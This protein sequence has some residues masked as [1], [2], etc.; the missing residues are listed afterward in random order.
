M[1]VVIGIK[2]FLEYICSHLPCTT[3]VK[4]ISVLNLGVKVPC[5][6]GTSPFFHRNYPRYHFHTW[7]VM[8]AYS[9]FSPSFVSVKIKQP[10]FEFPYKPSFKSAQLHQRSTAED[11]KCLLSA[12]LPT[13]WAE[14]MGQL[15]QQCV[16][17]GLKED[18]KLRSHQSLQLLLLLQREL[19]WQQEAETQ[20]YC[21]WTDGFQKSGT[22]LQWKSWWITE[23]KTYATYLTFWFSSIYC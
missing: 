11:A 23:E 8:T 18:S 3:T 4:K 10:D 17:P 20:V 14:T 1:T 19:L 22:F 9:N 16:L 15:S 12:R 21:N 2:Y 13:C 6:V 5:P 7:G